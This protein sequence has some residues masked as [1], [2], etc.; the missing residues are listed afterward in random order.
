MTTAQVYNPL[1][2]SWN[3]ISVPRRDE[4]EAAAG[5]TN[6][7]LSFILN[8]QSLVTVN[9]LIVP[10]SDYTGINTQVLIF[11]YALQEYDNVVIKE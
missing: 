2:G 8:N 9:G 1:T 7:N 10:F 11:N 5:A 6:F 3:L 4:F